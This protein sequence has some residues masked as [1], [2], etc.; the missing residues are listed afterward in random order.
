MKKLLSPETK[1]LKYLWLMYYND[2]LF[3]QGLITEEQRNEMLLKSKIYTV[4]NFVGNHENLVLKATTLTKC[5]KTIDKPQYIVYNIK[6][7]N[8]TTTESR[9]RLLKVSPNI[10][11]K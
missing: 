6:R 11:R 3:F 5:R 4:H 7:K 8:A 1:R 9:V 10:R 2:S